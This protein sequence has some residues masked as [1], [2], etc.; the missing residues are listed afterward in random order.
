MVSHRSPSLDRV[1]QA[2]SDPTRRFMLRRLAGE[3][4]NIRRLAEPLRM[5]FPA[6]SKH[7]RV[8]EAAGLVRRT[9]RGR[10][11]YCR[12]NAAPLAA[13]E[14]W[15]SYYRKFWTERLD[16]LAD[17]LDDEQTARSSEG[18]TKKRKRV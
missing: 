5:S 17:V 18:E 16:A 1:F 15:I 13:A 8:L 10:S 4:L 6:A 11:H 7:V 3:E 2:L 12:I 9:V 14:E